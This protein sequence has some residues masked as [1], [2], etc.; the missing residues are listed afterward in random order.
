MYPFAKRSTVSLTNACCTFARS[1]FFA[2]ISGTS[3]F[4]RRIV[5]AYRSRAASSRTQLYRT[6]PGTRPARSSS[7]TRATPRSHAARSA[8]GDQ[9]AFSARMGSAVVRITSRS[10]ERSIRLAGTA[11]ARC[12]NMPDSEIAIGR[13]ASAESR[14]PRPLQLLE[15]MPE[16]PP[17]F[18]YNQ[19]S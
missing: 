7:I 8:S 2:I 5:A 16:D 12:R 11:S 15:E 18:L 9:A 13:P 4:M 3:S 6:A 10:V 14:W 19:A 17:F 1:I